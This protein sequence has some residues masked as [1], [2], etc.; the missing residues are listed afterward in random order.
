MINGTCADLQDMQHTLHARTAVKKLLNYAS[1]LPITGDMDQSS[2]KRLASSTLSGCFLAQWALFVEGISTLPR[3]VPQ[4]VYSILTF[5]TLHSL[6]LGMLT[7]LSNCIY[8]YLSLEEILSNSHKPESD[9]RTFCILR[10]PLLRAGVTML[11]AIKTKYKAS[12]LY[13]EFQKNSSSQLNGIFIT[14]G[15]DQLYQ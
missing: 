13:V 2:S 1:C 9:R 11:S 12:S 14:G 4:D 15:L 7:K 3:S 5:E 8:T 10:N 6:R